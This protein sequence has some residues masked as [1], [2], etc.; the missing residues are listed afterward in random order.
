MSLED[1]RRP[2]RLNFIQLA[3]HIFSSVYLLLACVCLIRW[4]EPN[5]WLRLDFYSGGYLL[6]RASGSLHSLIVSRKAFRNHL[7]RQEWWGASSDRQGIRWVVILMLADLTVFL[8]YGHWRIVGSLERPLLQGIGF[9]LYMG[10]V[11]W[12]MWTDEYL[13]RYFCQTSPDQLP[14]DRGPYRYIRHPRYAAAILG[15]V[16][17]ALIFASALGW[18]L[19]LAWAALLLRKVKVE[20]AHLQKLFG[21]SYEAYQKTTARLIPGLY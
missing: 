5:P 7:V 2:K 21:R 6:L 4:G 12:Q 13:A 14:M 8:D 11:L 19:M 16:A 20:E 17:F 9:G 18:F 3:L 15:K 1:I 10:V